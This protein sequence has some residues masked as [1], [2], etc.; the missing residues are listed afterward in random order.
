MLLTGLMSTFCHLLKSHCEVFAT[1]FGRKLG[2]YLAETSQKVDM[3]LNVSFCEVSAK[4]LRKQIQLDA[5]HLHAPQ[6]NFDG[7]C[8][9]DF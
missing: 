2:R 7:T 5:N 3:Y 6:R 8:Q 9:L 4:F 1:P